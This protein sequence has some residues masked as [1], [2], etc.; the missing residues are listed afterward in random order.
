MK[1]QEQRRAQRLA[2]CRHFTGI[3]QEKCGLGISYLEVRDE[4]ARPYRWPCT[5]EECAISCDW[6]ELRTAEEVEAED[7][8]FE[9]RMKFLA[10]AR[11]AIVAL[12]IPHG[13]TD[14]PR[15]GA[16]LWFRVSSYNGHVH[17]KC[18]TKDCLS[19]ME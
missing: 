19:W 1:T 6:K 14:C 10:K 17:A 5:G 3:M 16:G 11:D 4:S 2:T 8:E 7:R 15:C 18:D 12:K 9:D 13:R